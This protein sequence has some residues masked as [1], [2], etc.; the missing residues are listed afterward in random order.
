MPDKIK[1]IGK[2]IVL[3]APSGAGKTS[4]S[5]RLIKD[6]PNLAFSVSATTRKPR[7]DEKDGIDYHF[8]SPREFQEGI[9]NDRFLEWEEIYGG[10]RY[11]TPYSEV[12]NNHNSGYFTLLDI[13]VNGALNVK[14]RYENECLTVFIKPPSLEVLEKR[15][16][17][18]GT[19]NEQSLKM[20][21][22]RARLELQMEHKFDKIIVN[23][24]F[25]QAYKDLKK[26]VEQYI[27]IYSQG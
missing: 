4:L 26:L 15:L 20:R 5:Q 18:R 16:K 11:G 8:I 10:V 24:D 27:H 21:L 17:K 1:S 19:E 13:E 2:V 7:D 22:D 3:V 6:F 12:E 23:D 25:D 9:D 14:K